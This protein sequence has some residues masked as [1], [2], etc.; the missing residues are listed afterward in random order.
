MDN[1]HQHIG[2]RLTETPYAAGNV[3]GETKLLLTEDQAKAELQEKA[4][5]DGREVVRFRRVKAWDPVAYS[6]VERLDACLHE[7]RCF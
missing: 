7:G 3:A 5:L 6:Q 2:R 4:R 1:L